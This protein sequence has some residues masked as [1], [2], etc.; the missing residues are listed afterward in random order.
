MLFNV[1][2]L[3]TSSTCCVGTIIIPRTLA[4]LDSAIAATSNVFSY[5]Q[6]SRNPVIVTIPLYAIASW[7]CTIFLALLFSMMKAALRQLVILRTS[8]GYSGLF[9]WLTEWLSFF[10]RGDDSYWR[11]WQG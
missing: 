3:L 4:A 7:L 11:S 2:N 6:M 1:T 10:R 5:V 9:L 8:L